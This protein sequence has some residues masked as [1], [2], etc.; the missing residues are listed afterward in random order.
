[1]NPLPPNA[2]EL[3][4]AYLDGQAAP[5]EI[6][7]VESSPELMSRVETLRLLSDQL[8]VPVS[9]PTAQ[10]EAHLAAALDA[11]DALFTS[12]TNNEAPRATAVRATAVATAAS[13][14][15][16]SETPPPVAS[17]EAA[18]ER[19]RPRR[20]NTGLIAAAAAAAVLFVA[21]AAVSL[22]GG[23]DSLDV[24]TSEVAVEAASGADSA[25][26]AMEDSAADAAIDDEE[27]MDVE[28]AADRASGA[29]LS[30]L[31]TPAGTAVPEAP[32][33]QSAN[34]EAADATDDAEEAVEEEATADES[35]ADD[36]EGL[37][38]EPAED[39]AASADGTA[40]FFLG[41]F[42]DEE[43]L[44]TALTETATDDLLA[45]R[46]SVDADQSIHC[47]TEVPDLDTNSTVALVG[48]AIIEIVPGQDTP[49]LVEIY[50]L[51]TTKTA[52]SVY[53]VASTTCEVITVVDK[54]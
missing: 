52:A 17:L 27:A 34:A 41:T 49:M 9:V 13:T 29:S 1:M 5:D 48:E 10:K 20:F 51:P 53:V 8:A 21:V 46:L 33:A 32:A 3:V 38:S 25:S 43:A 28:D 4:S 31:P 50:V 18:R 11:F 16:A 42:Q 2:D 44:F 7:I 36:A 40:K 6:V 30:E 23:N 26:A 19:R 24:A 35:A 15:A 22:G 54:N 39:D 14:S 12:D 37:F 45:S 47:Q